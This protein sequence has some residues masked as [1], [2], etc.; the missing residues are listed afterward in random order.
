MESKLILGDAIEEMKKLPNNSIDLVLTDPPYGTTH[1]K[2]DSIIPFDEM[3]EQLLRIT[4]DRTPIILFAATPFDKLLASSN[5]KMYKHDWIWMKEQG[6]GQLNAKR[7]PLRQHEYILLFYKK[8]PLYKP[9]FS[10]AEPYHIKRN[11]KS[12][13]LN[14]YNDISQKS[15]TENKDGKRYPTSIL[16]YNRELRNRYHPTQKPQEL[17]KYLIKTYTNEGDMVLDFTMGGGSTPVAAK[18]L[19]RKYI[20]IENS[21]KYYKSAKQRVT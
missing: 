1:Q 15:E 5:I 3:W 8:Q 17:L 11:I 12:E 14:T 7:Q 6:T 4:K 16:R 9:Q 19:N 20:G 13:G 21:E 2:W 10:Y 18:G